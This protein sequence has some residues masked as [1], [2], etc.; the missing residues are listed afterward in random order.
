MKRLIALLALLPL[1]AMGGGQTVMTGNHRH[2]FATG[3][4][5]AVLPVGTPVC[6]LPYGNSITVSYTPHAVGD[7]IVV[8]GAGNGNNVTNVTDNLSTVYSNPVNYT[9]GSANGYIWVD[10]HVPSGVT[11]II[12]TL[13]GTSYQTACVSEYSGVVRT[14]NTLNN[15]GWSTATSY[16]ASLTMQDA[17]NYAVFAVWPNLVTPAP[18]ATSGTIFGLAGT[19]GYFWTHINTSATPGVV[20]VGANLS[21]STGEITGLELRSN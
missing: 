16:S 17:H 21:S 15:G 13:S 18:T 14:G 4:G 5:G 12:V 7:T 2:V 19:E 6:T 10:L 9:S 8:T 11:S 1:L 3:G 20:T